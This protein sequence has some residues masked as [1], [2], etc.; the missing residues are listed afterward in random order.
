MVLVVQGW[1]NSLCS[2]CTVQLMAYGVDA[3]TEVQVVDH[4]VLHTTRSRKCAMFN[5]M[6]AVKAMRV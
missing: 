6:L 5:L 1:N 2:N 3:G 4:Y